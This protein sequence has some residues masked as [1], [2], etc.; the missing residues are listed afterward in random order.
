MNFP[1]YSGYPLPEDILEDKRKYLREL[2]PRKMVEQFNI[3]E[4]DIHE[5]TYADGA[6]I[7]VLVSKGKSLIIHL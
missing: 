2:M 3:E 1:S 6:I 5:T 7:I 4:T